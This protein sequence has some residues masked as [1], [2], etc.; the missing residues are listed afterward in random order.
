MK[1]PRGRPKYELKLFTK[2]LDVLNL[3]DKPGKQYSFK[4][5]HS[6]LKC[7]R[8][9]LFRIIKNLEEAAFLEKDAESGKYCL[10]LKLLFFGSMVEPYSYIKRIAR[11]LLEKLSAQCDETVQLV[12]LHR[13]EALYIDIIEG[14]RA[15][16]VIS[17]V[18][19]ILPAHCSGVG[20]VLL[21]AL[22]EVEL[23]RIVNPLGLKKLTPNT[24]TSFEVLREELHRV[25][26]NG[27]AIDNEES[28][29]GL[30]CVAAPLFDS[31][32]KVVSALSISG[33]RDRFDEDKIPML[34]AAA[35]TTAREISAHLKRLASI[36]GLGY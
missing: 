36:S 5:I 28:E 34:V 10:G 21:A 27:Y 4:E 20:K 15:I 6:T 22:P 25:R 26:Q 7:N 24:I 8:T 33:P 19:M 9:S 29:V 11:P 12:T 18:G 2:A 13:G 1:D 14:K 23:R 31:K 17:R 16:H 35:K 3:F 30:K 32:G